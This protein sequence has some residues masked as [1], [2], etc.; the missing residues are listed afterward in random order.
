M[1]DYERQKM[2]QVMRNSRVFRSLG[3]REAAEILKNSRPKAT[4]ATRED[5]GSLYEAGDS[6][7]TEEGVFD[8]VPWRQP[9]IYVKYAVHEQCSIICI[10]YAELFILL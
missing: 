4:K 1:T 7:D 2:E 10:K 6:E 8:K 3:I 5:S 9:N